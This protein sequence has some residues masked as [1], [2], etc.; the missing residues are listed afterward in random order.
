MSKLLE[1]KGI[2][3]SFPGVKALEQV[4][5]EL[6]QGEVL[7]L[8]GENGA[9]KSTLLKVLSGVHIP[10]EGEI[11]INGEKKNFKIP[12]DAAEEGIRIIYQELNHYDELSVAENI[13]VG[14]MPKSSPLSVDWKQ[15][16]ERAA[17]A[18]KKLNLDIDP[19][20]LVKDLSTAQ[21]QLIEI[22]RA[23]VSNIKI[24]VMDEPTSALNDTEVK[25]LLAL[26]KKLAQEGI[27][28]IYISHRLEELFE[29]ADRVQVMRDGK[30]VAV[31]PMKEVSQEELI[32]LMVGREI[33]DMYPKEDIPKGEVIFEAKHL[34]NKTLKDISFTVRAGEILGV[35]GLM[36]AG[37]T[38]MCKAIFG[39][40]KLDKGEIYLHGKK[41][42][43]KN[44]SDAKKA[45]IAYLPN[46]R[47]TEGLILSQTLRDNFASAMIDR[48]TKVKGLIVNGKKISQNAE[49]WMKKLSVS[50]PSANTKAEALSGGNQQKIVVGKWLETSPDVIMLNEPTRGIDVGAKVEI[51]KIME[52]LCKQ[53]MAVIL[54]S[55]EQAEILSLT[56]RAIVLC[57][58]RL[59]G[60]ISREDYSQERLM[61]YAIGGE[62]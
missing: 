57:E 44:V 1:M 30:R 19:R 16:N 15:M 8:L 40:S 55:S 14:K 59:T 4:D 28:V 34:T 22:A 42:A 20:T 62:N 17:E 23:L 7:A 13:F 41:V 39:A 11:Y 3:K 10:D 5:L 37:R 43:I 51:Y 52:D 56:D 50:A 49:K 54:V 31:R 29:V 9:G 27:G 32:R 61:E 58:G 18:L 24:L 25:S 36:G 47:K 33:K 48:F 21:K 12:A 35:F 26:V 46:D 38:E 53:G 2:S 45:K 6:N 60:E